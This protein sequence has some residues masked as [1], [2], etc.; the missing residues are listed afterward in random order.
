MGRQQ[1]CTSVHMLNHQRK[2]EIV[3]MVHVHV[4]PRETGFRFSGTRHPELVV[5]RNSSLEKFEGFNGIVIAVFDKF[6]PAFSGRP[7]LRVCPGFLLSDLPELD[8][9]LITSL[10]SWNI[11][12]R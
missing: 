3:H 12:G 7:V 8:F 4:Q 1:V 9:P 6:F 10:R 2:S 5:S 11:V